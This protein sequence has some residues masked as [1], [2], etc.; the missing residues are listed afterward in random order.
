MKDSTPWESANKIFKKIR[1]L[2]QIPAHSIKE[3]KF[4]QK[5]FHQQKDL[6]FKAYNGIKIIRVLLSQ[7]PEAKDIKIPEWLYNGEISEF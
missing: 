3:N 6:I 1:R 5:Y 7:H 2:R 4:D